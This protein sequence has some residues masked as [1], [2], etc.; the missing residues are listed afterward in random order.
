MPQT[1]NRRD[2]EVLVEALD[3]DLR[4]LFTLPANSIRFLKSGSPVLKAVES[5]P[6]SQAIPY[7]SIIGDRGKGDSP[8]STDGIVPFWSSHLPTAVS[9]KIV[10]R[11]H[12]A[13]QY[14]ETADEIARILR[15][16]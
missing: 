12:S 2:R 14:P 3:D 9:E 6:L 16:Y 13:P 4:G 5:L 11:D 7:H 10:P 15:R 1:V 8:D